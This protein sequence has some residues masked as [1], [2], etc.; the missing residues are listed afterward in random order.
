M[1]EERQR[2]FTE[3]HKCEVSDCEGKLRLTQ[4]NQNSRYQTAG[5]KKRLWSPQTLTRMA[6]ILF[7]DNINTDTL[8]YPNSEAV[9]LPREPAGLNYFHAPENLRAV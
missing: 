6:N 8:F 1:L 4:A 7:T 9:F 5:E 3:N 2:Y